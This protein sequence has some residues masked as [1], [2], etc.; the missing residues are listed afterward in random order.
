[1]NRA[2]PGGDIRADPTLISVTDEAYLGRAINVARLA[3]ANGNHPFGA[4]LVA[5]DG[6]IIEGQNSVVTAGDP[7]GHAETNLVRLASAR[8]SRDEL[9]ASTL[10]TSTEP[11]VMCSGA[12]YWAGIGRVAYALPEQ[13]LGE[14]VPDQGGEATLD[15]PC[16]EV[17]ARGGNT[18]IVAGPA[19]VTEAADVHAGFWDAAT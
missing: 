7:T 3:R 6:T 12:I 5:G 19:L 8:L 10:Y 17:F 11:C 4:I 2:H 13:M 18:V 9:R 14:M 15:L 16:R 1:M